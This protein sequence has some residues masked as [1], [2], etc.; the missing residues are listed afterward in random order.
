MVGMRLLIVEDEPD[1][2]SSLLR[3]FRDEGY[4]CD[5]AAD[6]ESGLF[7]AENTDYDAI[8]L[9]VMLPRV[10]GWEILERLRSSK[11]TPVLLLTARDSVADRIRGLDSGADDYVLKP[12]E[13]GELI[14]R[15]RALIR[16]A[17][18]TAEPVL[19][20]GGISIDTIARTV[21]KGG[22]LAP[23]TPREYALVEY[24]ALHRG[25]VISRTTLYE[26]LFD[27]DD[28]TFS[29][30]LDVYVSNIRRKLGHEFIKTRRGHGYLVEASV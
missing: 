21:H 16:R 18:N 14:A 6:G 22:S 8:I 17:T 5:A 3:A 4:A 24:L 27:E 15:V 25:A 11:G 2:R 12:F 10:T 23:L 19:Q 9:D 30:L 7:M 28:N 13:L 1:L 29:N 20:I 26:H